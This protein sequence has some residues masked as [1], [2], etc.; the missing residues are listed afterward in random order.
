MNLKQDR[1][2]RGTAGN[3]NHLMETRT[4]YSPVHKSSLGTSRLYLEA[5]L[6]HVRTSKT[7]LYI[8]F[9]YLIDPFGKFGSPSPD[10]AEQCKSSATHSYQCVQYFPV[11]KQ[12][13]GCQCLRFLTCT[14]MLMHVISHGG[15]TD[16]V[17]E[18]ALNTDWEKNP[19]PHGG[20]EPASVFRLA[21]QSDA[22]PT[23]RSR[24]YP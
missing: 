2:Q 14:Q 20:I 22:L 16:T 19:L 13:Y 8:I 4:I 3:T 6:K 17:R 9:K 1:A 10:K 23:E 7:A 15:C 5:C 11:S 24:R 21:F 18:S 12:W